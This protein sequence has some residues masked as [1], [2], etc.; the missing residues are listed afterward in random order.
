[1]L[2]KNRWDKKMA[3]KTL[4]LGTLFTGNVEPLIAALGKVK[5]AM[6][7][8]NSQLEQQAKTAILGKKHLTTLGSELS[9]YQKIMGGAVGESKKYQSALATLQAQHK[10][11]GTG[12]TV[13]KD[14][15]GKVEKAIQTTA[16]RMNAAGRNGQQ[17]AKTANR[18]ALTNG[19]LSK[20]LKITSDR[21]QTVSS[22]AKT[23][24]KT[25]GG[26]SGAMGKT[27]K[28]TKKLGKDQQWMGKQISKV[29]GGMNRL[30]AA[31]KVTASYG[32][33]AA[34]IFS[35]VRAMS[36]GAKEVIN[37]SQAL[38]NLQAITG[39]TDAEIA[40]MDKTLR[41]VARTTKFSTTETAD[42]MVLLGQAG[43]D[44]GESINAMQAVANLATGTLSSM[45]LVTDLLSTTIRAFSLNAVE[46]G[47]VADV[48]ANAINKS[49]LTI[50]KLRIAFNFVGAAA[51]QTGLSLEE[52]TASLM[53]LANNGLRASTMGTGLRQVLSRLLAPTSKLKA[54]FAAYG[55]ELDKVS[56]A[57]VGYQQALKAILPF[58]WNHEKGMMDMGKAYQLFGLRGAQA[59]AVLG[60]SLVSGEFQ[61]AL[62][63]TYEA[64]TSI[65]MAAKQAEGLGLKFKQM[66]DRA[67]LVAVALG[68][69]GVGGMLKGFVDTMRS[70]FEAIEKFVKTGI[71]SFLIQA[72]F[73]TGAI[74]LNITAFKV[75]ARWIGTTGLVR[76]FRA[77][78]T[79]FVL[80][81]SAMVANVATLKLLS[82]SLKTVLLDL[83]V[84]LLAHPYLVVAGIVA[85]FVVIINKL[86]TANKKAA[87]KAAVLAVELKRSAKGLEAWVGILEAANKKEFRDY[88]TAIERF[89]Q[90]NKELAKELMKTFKVAD[91]SVVSFEKM[92]AAMDK[93]KIE[94]M[95]ESIEKTAGATSKWSEEIDKN[96]GLHGKITR[97]VNMF[98]F[99]LR[100]SIGVQEDAKVATEKYN[101]SII[102]LAE[103][104]YKL[105][106]MEGWNIDDII[107]YIKETGTVSEKTTEAIRKL[108]DETAKQE[109][110]TIRIRIEKLKKA[111]QELPPEYKKFYDQLDALSQINFIKDYNRMK[112]TV[113]NHK[114]QLATWEASEEEKIEVSKKAW[115]EWFDDQKDKEES[116][117]QKAEKTDGAIVRAAK[118]AVEE[119]MKL[120]DIEKKQI[121]THLNNLKKEYSEYFADLSKMEM[122]TITS[123]ISEYQRKINDISAMY[124]KN[125]RKRVKL[126]READL[127]FKERIA[128][129][130]E[131]ERELYDKKKENLESWR[132]T[133]KSA[134]DSAISN[135]EQ[136]ADKAKELEE[137]LHSFRLSVED[138]IRSLRRKTMT[139]EKAWYDLKKQVYEKLSQADE[140]YS[141]DTEEGRKKA[142]NLYK[143]AIGLADGLASEI[144]EGDRII[145]T[146]E[147]GVEEAIRATK[148]AREGVIKTTEDQISAAERMAGT[149]KASAESIAAAM[150]KVDKTLKD[151]MTII[152]ALIKKL[153][154]KMV[155][156]I[157]TDTSELDDLENQ[158]DR[159]QRK[160]KR[161]IKTSVEGDTIVIGTEPTGG[162][163]QHGG[164]VGQGGGTVGAG[165]YVFD[166]KSVNKFGVNFFRTLQRIVSSS[167]GIVTK[168]M[169]SLMPQIQGMQS[170]NQTQSPFSGILHTI[171]LKINNEPHI[172]YGEEKVVNDLDRNLR[173]NRL[174]TV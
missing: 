87:E 162:E 15:L 83:K 70:A 125:A 18:V 9:S 118:K 44:A 58:I 91:L 100:G 112:A 105:G 46:S 21:F 26:M 122:R 28:E 32:L 136:Y 139:D 148:I 20:K 84:M 14:K 94:K 41:T 23:T 99:D 145:I 55:I 144:K 65:E 61:K 163:Y 98:M 56:P 1:M 62:A 6:I 39:A 54:A 165:E 80:V 134:Y 121:D 140:E 104:L 11:A 173:R 47:R 97:M 120:L 151:L 124:E 129:E 168:T 50:D 117:Q 150:G 146:E 25:M 73:M 76:Y 24:T 123:S 42:G 158:L 152:D 49:K 127:P 90:D 155:V 31:M 68:D 16:L 142:N 135:A 89:V 43:L 67:R 114:K 95:K 74:W 102:E 7:S 78:R 69:A 71:G 164:L 113:A 8:L 81:R 79:E 60:K 10:T 40:A 110:K 35:V 13:L 106:K 3:E 119:K 109:E 161:K 157:S 2:W 34:A 111:I 33:A 160:A 92:A 72:S 17:F 4:I 171:N 128:R 141:R 93:L 159:I 51:A 138:K 167:S 170:R 96:T 172:I 57:I 116:R 30:K 53:V 103:S 130:I 5:T 59:I 166:V 149:F 108:L 27:G 154:E 147:K 143:E 115:A 29:T 82:M 156:K 107:K 22:A 63:S 12:L 169:E 174:V 37:Y 45:Q 86:A 137:G 38:K 19:V 126:V 153:S 64:S 85:S 101:G 132:S 48:M 66:A 52:T 77:L 133:L 36:A 88:E 131:I 75:L